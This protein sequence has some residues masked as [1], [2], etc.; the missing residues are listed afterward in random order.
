MA[1][2]SRA[3]LLIAAA[4]AA[5]WAGRVDR[6]VELAQAAVSEVD[7]S[8]DPVQSARM[9]ERLASYLWELGDHAASNR[10]YDEAAAL[11][12]D[13]PPSPVKARVLVVEASRGVRAG[14]YDEGLLVC[15]EALAMAESV[16]ARPEQGR[17]LNWIGVALTM[18]GHV[19]EG[20][21]SLRRAIEIAE[22]DDLLEDLFRGLGN[23]TYMLESAGRLDECLRVAFDG[24]DRIR[25][26]GLEHTRSG[27]VLLNNMCA[28]MLQLGRWEEA[29]TLIAELLP[30]RTNSETVFARLTLAE[31]E[32]ARGQY[33]EAY[34]RLEQVREFAASVQQPQFTAAI[35][36]SVAEMGV[37]NRE[38]E[39]ARAAVAEGL[40]AIG[41]TEHPI[42]R[43]RLCALG[44]RNEADAGS[45]NVDGL[46]AEV[47]R[48]VGP[49]NQ[50]VLPDVAALLRQCQA[51]RSRVD[52]DPVNQPAVW[53]EVAETWEELDRPYPAAYARWREAEAAWQ[54]DD[55]ASA[56]QAVLDAYQAAETLRAEPL[57][58]ALEDLL[59][60]QGLAVVKVPDP[61]SGERAAEP[62]EDEYRLT[63][64]ERQVL[65]LL[66]AAKTN[67]QIASAL[68]T[69]EKPL[70]AKTVSVHISRIY[71]KLG[72]SGRTAAILK[73]TE[74][75]LVPAPKA[76]TDT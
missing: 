21:A 60:R 72:V 46:M 3:D 51:E 62:V 45:T 38:Y 58:R 29:A 53:R 59:R 66:C 71:A 25:Q 19:V 32:V 6:A 5:R 1:E 76:Q 33:A 28:A 30:G 44:L 14:R 22:A 31:I 27:A 18:Q 74:L 16:G 26:T 61:V 54:G 73:A 35:H 37:W 49:N 63:P 57:R 17:A 50:Q 41:D 68:A 23:L 11:L 24:L 52:G 70:S 20:L 10:A 39:K 48:V 42:A 64:R 55:N 4:D 40:D 69:P 43:L 65:A 75:K 15:R 13:A 34:H 67:G 7:P 36:T 12:R 9:H 47:S 8:A 56:G 2:R